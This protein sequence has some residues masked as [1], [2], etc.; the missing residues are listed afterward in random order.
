[1]TTPCASCPI[2]P[3]CEAH[4]HGPPMCERVATVP[5]WRARFEG[6][7]AE[8]EEDRPAARVPKTYRYPELPAADQAV[9]YLAMEACEY[10]APPTPGR[11]ACF[12]DCS[13]FGRVVSEAECLQCQGAEA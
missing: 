7:A 3:A 6:F 13:R 10:R 11:C 5:K 4:R 12:R 1:M 9:L 8:P 2:G